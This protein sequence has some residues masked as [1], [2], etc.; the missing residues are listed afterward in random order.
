[1]LVGALTIKVVGY[2]S[3]VGLFDGIHN[4]FLTLKKI[5]PYSV[6]AKLKNI[7]LDFFATCD[8]MVT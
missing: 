2:P 4:I 1:M 6:L 5:I 3:A 8:I 7:M